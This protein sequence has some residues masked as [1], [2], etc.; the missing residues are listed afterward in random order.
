MNFTEQHRSYQRYADS[1]E[2]LAK[3]YQNKPDSYRHFEHM[4]WAR[5]QRETGERT[6]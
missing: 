4:A 6:S 2:R 3:R 5:H 1:T